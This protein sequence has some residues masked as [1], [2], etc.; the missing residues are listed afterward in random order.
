MGIQ[1]QK[2]RGN[3]AFGKGDGS[4]QSRGGVVDPTPNPTK[5]GTGP[6]DKLWRDIL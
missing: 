2:K 6:G 1:T 5:E 3:S 4:V